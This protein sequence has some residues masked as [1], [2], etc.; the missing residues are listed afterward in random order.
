MTL[1]AHLD[2]MK[3]ELESAQELLEGGQ[4]EEARRQYEAVREQL[5]AEGLE[6]AY[7]FYGLAETW[8]HERAQTPQRT[9][10]ALERGFEACCEAV[11]LDPIHPAHQDQ[12]A[13]FGQRLR[14]F[15]CAPAQLPDE[16]AAPR[17]YATLLRAGEAD[18]ACHV[19]MAR[20]LAG[21]GRGEEARRLLKATVLLEP[22]CA[23]AWRLLAEIA[24]GASD[25]AC[26]AECEARAAALAEVAAPFGVPSPDALC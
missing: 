12:F 21:H 1:R 19:A 5:E 7:V 17:L 11:R 14:T 6:S 8:R 13:H 3:A 9:L 15:F 4:P 18:A 22:A 2:E 24:R 20:H 10:E 23:E 26:A 16:A 25:G